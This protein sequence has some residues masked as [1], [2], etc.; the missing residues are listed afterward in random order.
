MEEKKLLGMPAHICVA[1]SILLFPLG[2]VALCI[3]KA[4]EKDDKKAI[5]AGFIF[6]ALSFIL[7]TLFIVFA[8]IKVLIWIVLIIDL[9]VTALW[10]IFLVKAFMN[11]YWKLPVVWD[12][13]GMFIGEKKEDAKEESSEEAPKTEEEKTEE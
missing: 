3:E 7:N 11:N 13:A 9:A 5:I 2:I 12:L 1:L 10:I 4:M 8:G 6:A